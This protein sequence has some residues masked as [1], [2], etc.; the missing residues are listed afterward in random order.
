MY[1]LVLYQLG[2]I[3]KGIQAQHVAT[4]Y[5]RSHPEN[6]E[7]KQWADKDK[8][9]IILSAGGSIELTDAISQLRANNITH[10]IFEE[11]DLYDKPTIVCFLVD[12][13]VWD[14]I[15]YPEPQPTFADLLTLFD[16]STPSAQSIWEKEIGG[17]KNVFL[18]SFLPKFRRA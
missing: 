7:Y 11:P 9:T 6:L 4:A 18:R 17:K 14:K 15:K 8:T 5:G 10:E 13:R 3:H 12:E 1:Y 16:P 2:G